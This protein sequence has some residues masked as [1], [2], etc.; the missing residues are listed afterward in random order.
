[1]T[2]GAFAIGTENFMIAGLLPALAR[3]LNVGLPAAGHLVT[4]FSLTYAIGA[5]VMA[6][7]TAGLERR[8]LLAIAMGGFTLANLLAALAPGYFGLLAARLLLALSAASFMPAASGYAATQG[9]PQRH[10]RALSMVYNGLTLAIIA[11][12]P[13]GVL[14]GQGFGWRATFLG[15]AG[16][17]ALSLLGTLFRLPLQPAGA[18]ASLRLAL[19]VRGDML[20]VL[21]VSVLTIAGTFT[22]YTYIGAFL[23]SAADISTRG[24][25]LVLMGFGLASAIGTRLGGAAADRWGGRP[26]VI[27]GGSPVLL[28]YLALSLSPMLGPDLAIPVLLAA[29]SLWGFSSWGLITAQQARLVALAPH[30]ASVSLSLNSSAIYLGSA[31]GAAAGALVVAHGAVGRLGLVSAGFSLA[32]LLAVLVSARSA[33]K[34]C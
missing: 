2:L 11:G 6:V 15:V 21:A 5:P 8:R 17:G 13:L 3:D 19:A 33:G 28:A 32:A 31:T 23:A 9:G 22:L 18:T 25:P 12:V 20:M 24:L 34:R 10:G 29:M 27:L 1:L 16:L 14:V 26:T 7:L 30:A 4:A